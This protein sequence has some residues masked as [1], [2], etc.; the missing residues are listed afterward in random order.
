MARWSLKNSVFACF[1]RR[2]SASFITL[3]MNSAGST[4]SSFT[5]GSRTSAIL[6]SSGISAGRWISTACRP[7][8]PP[9]R[10][11]SARSG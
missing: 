9:R 3:P 5:Q 1:A 7:S 2:C 4:T 6:L 10:S 11:R 8:S